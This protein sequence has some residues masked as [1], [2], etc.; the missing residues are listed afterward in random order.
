MSDI[1]IEQLL[2]ERDRFIDY[3]DE[4][5]DITVVRGYQHHIDKIDAELKA[6]GF[7]GCLN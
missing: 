6:R 5:E 3:R 1:E 7:E 2:K 4:A